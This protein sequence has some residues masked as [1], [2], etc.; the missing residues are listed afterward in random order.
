MVYLMLLITA[1]LQAQHIEVILSAADVNQLLIGDKLVRQKIS[2]NHNCTL[3]LRNQW[4]PV[5][6]IRS[7]QG[8]LSLPQKGDDLPRIIKQ[9]DQAC[10]QAYK[11]VKSPS[12]LK[13]MMENFYIPSRCKE[14]LLRHH[15]DLVYIN[16]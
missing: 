5:H 4:F 13:R 9:V 1:F 10:L 14:T 15:S 12:R 8:Q 16:Q 11:Q 2:D 3:E 7:L 6:C